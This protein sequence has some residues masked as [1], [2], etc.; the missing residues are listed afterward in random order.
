MDVS[1]EGHSTVSGVDVACYPWDFGK[2]DK[3]D[4]Y[5]YECDWIV[6]DEGF[7]VIYSGQTWMASLTR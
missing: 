6:G 5:Q 2:M 1:G 7:E 4:M 3:G